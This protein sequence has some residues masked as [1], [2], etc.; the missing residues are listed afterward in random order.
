MPETQR[1]D[2]AAVDEEVARRLKAIDEYS[3]P[4][5]TPEYR[6]LADLETAKRGRIFD[7]AARI[8]EERTK[9]SDEL[10]EDRSA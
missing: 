8:V 2:P 3:D 9:R 5:Q 10:A 6:D 4:R 7:E 1:P